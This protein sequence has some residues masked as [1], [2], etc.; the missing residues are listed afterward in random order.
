MMRLHLCAR[1]SC[2][3]FPKSA[4]K[5]LRGEKGYEDFCSSSFDGF[6]AFAMPLIIADPLCFDH[7]ST[8]ESNLV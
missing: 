3:A 2:V 1:S 5:G 6:I 8:G 4:L 7:R